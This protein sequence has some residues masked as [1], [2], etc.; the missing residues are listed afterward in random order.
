V[1]NFSW[2][3]KKISALGRVSKLA[4]VEFQSLGTEK[5][6]NELYLTVQ[7]CIVYNFKTTTALL[8][9]YT[10]VLDSIRSLV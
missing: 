6:I 5:F 2:K 8:S 3:N 1:E 9:L 7:Y 4:A 10:N